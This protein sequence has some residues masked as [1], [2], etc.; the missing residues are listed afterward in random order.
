LWSTWGPDSLRLAE[1]RRTLPCSAITLPSITALAN[2]AVAPPAAVLHAA[3]ALAPAGVRDCSSHGWAGSPAAFWST[4]P[5]PGPS[6]SGWQHERR[7]AQL[8]PPGRRSAK[9]SL[10]TGWVCL[11]A[12]LRRSGNARSTRHADARGTATRAWTR[13]LLPTC[14]CGR[15]PAAPTGGISTAGARR[16]PPRRP[17]PVSTGP[18]A[19]TNLRRREGHRCT[20]ISPT[21]WSSDR[22]GSVVG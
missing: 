5:R 20:L 6:G 4:G 13:R 3:E 11:R 10:A 15:S 1:S 14:R 19:P 2:I 21:S 9:P 22:S 12:T 16:A 8:A 7:A 17:R 18:A